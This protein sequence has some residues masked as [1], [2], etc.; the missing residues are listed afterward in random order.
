MSELRVG[1]QATAGPAPRRAHRLGWLLGQLRE[2]YV[3]LIASQMLTGAVAFAANIL[4]VR[5]LTPTHR[6]EVAL[7]LQVTY[8]ATQVLLLG[9]ERSFVATYHNV[10]PAPAVKAYAK[11]LL[12]PCAVGLAGAVLYTAVAPHSHNPG[13]VLVAMLAWYTVVEASSLATR[14]I[15]IAVGRV[16]DF[17]MC[18]VIESALLLV[19]LAGLYATHASHP[20]VWFLAYLVAGAV[21]TI[22]YL[23]VWLRLPPDPAAVPVRHEQA[24]MVRREGLS[25]FPA[26][27]SNMAMLRVDRLVIPALA[28][29]AALGL[30][31]SVATMTELLAWPLRAYA[32]SRLGR[33]RAAHQDGTLRAAPIVLAAAVYTL[34]AVPLVAGTLYLLI[35]P[36]FGHQYAPA[37][38]VVLPLVIAAGLYALSR[39]SLGLLIARGHGTLVSAAEITGFAVSFAVYLLLIPRLGILGAAYG[40]LAGY[41]ACLLFALV[42]SRLVKDRS[43]V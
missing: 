38:V 26:A 20:E 8:L 39:I 42:A 36:V 35:V 5:S 10:A 11:L 7:L 27:I 15:A 30:Y 12:I 1:Q 9:T 29:T 23:V 43:H 2:P 37:K 14:S 40:S 4:M 21:P 31:T 24:R 22:V 3:Q 6:G 17:M 28:S 18:R 19:M 41:G 33:W 16:R 32:D 34:V 13:P 25:L